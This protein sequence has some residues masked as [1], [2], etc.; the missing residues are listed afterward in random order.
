MASRALSLTRWTAL[1]ATAEAIGMAA[2]ATAAK[3][4][5]ALVGEPGNGRES[6]LALCLVVAGGL[7]EGIALGA[8]Q[9][10]GLGRL[11]P[12]LN[13]RRWL[14]ITV[15][16]RGRLLFLQ[17]RIGAEVCRVIGRRRWQMF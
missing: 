2:A 5:Q 3:T 15:A 16:P 7:V 13:R 12:G 14:L 8:L 11:L 9:A 17:Q 10:A 4:S 6:A 1:C